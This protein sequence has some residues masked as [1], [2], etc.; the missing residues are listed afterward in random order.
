MTD[1][2]SGVETALAIKAPVRAA[3]TANIILSGLQTIDG[4]ELVEGDR[5]LVKDQTDQTQNGIYEADTSGWDRAP[6]F[7]GV[8]DIVN[9]TQFKVTEGNTNADTWWEVS[10]PN[11]ITI[12]EDNITFSDSGSAA[13]AEQ[14]ALRAEAA[15]AAAE[16]AETNA[17][18]AETAANN[19]A[20][21]ALQSEQNALAHEEGAEDA[22]VAAE[23][24]QAAAEAAAASIPGQIVET[25]TAG[26]GI[27]VGGTAADPVVSLNLNSENQWLAQQAPIKG[28]LT[29][30]ATINWDA[31]VN[32]QVVRVTL[33]GNRT[34]AAPTNIIQDAM[35]VIRVQQDATGGR[36]LAWDSAFKWPVAVAPTLTPEAGGVDIFSFIGG[37][38]NTL[39][40][41][42]QDIR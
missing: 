15:Q 31:D 32:G 9:G 12:D 24:A 41:I 35:Y 37:A 7:D 38:G 17:E 20:A 11:P 6:D 18:A 2:L 23:A 28:T 3:T 36:T 30:G 4:V 5:V 29:D 26:S 13:N 8:N 25:L 1:R 19:Y 21:A 40:F 16:L 14:Y 33:G 34:M 27:T 42:G 39:E 22:Q 10:A